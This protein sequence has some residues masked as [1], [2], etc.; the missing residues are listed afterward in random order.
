MIE[1]TTGIV[2]DPVFLK[3]DQPSHPENAKRLESI[4][5]G[6]KE[7]GLYQKVEPIKSRRA[8]IKEISFCHTK[9][10][11]NYVNEFCEK[12]GGHLDPD[13]YANEYSFDAAS[14][15][16]GSSIDLTKSVINGDLKNGF[17]LLRP[18]GHHALANRSMG[19]CL[20]GNISIAAKAAL[21][22]P[23]I[24]KVA[25]VDFDVHHG[26]G[27]QALIG[28]NPNIL[29]IST[30]Q[31]PFYPGTGSIGE[32]GSGQAEGTIINIPLEAG[33]G[34]HSFKIVYE[35]IMLPALRR[36]NPDILLISAGF[37]AHWDDPLANLNLTLTGFNRISRALIKLADEICSGKI[38]FF[39]EGGY[40]LDVLRN[41][42]INTTKG[43]IGIESFDDTLGQLNILEPNINKLINELHQ[44]HKL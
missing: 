41:G 6:L 30:H 31:Y 9:E 26:N 27:T 21:Q 1:Q 7:S 14:M 39:L 3:H 36:F 13:T 33:V 11:I 4:L 25:I 12:G 16:V 10:Y 44:I 43:L 37:D 28:D 42:V 8:E 2:F 19:F 29:F 15:A 22:N 18:P 23:K 38:I 20:F 5:T 35:E 34:D 24:G 32:I 40:N 17:A